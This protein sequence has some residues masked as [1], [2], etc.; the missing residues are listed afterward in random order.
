V[1][2]TQIDYATGV[3]TNR[4]TTAGLFNK[5]ALQLLLAARNGFSHAAL[6]RPFPSLSRSAA[7]ERELSHSVALAPPNL[8]CA[9]PPRIRRSAAV[10]HKWDRGGEA[11]VEFWPA[12][13]TTTLAGDPGQK[14]CKSLEKCPLRDSNPDYEI[15]SLAV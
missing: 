5:D 3:S 12:R 6:A 15:K 7:V 8:D 4:A 11:L 1:V 14:T 13:Q 10:L 9:L 2:E